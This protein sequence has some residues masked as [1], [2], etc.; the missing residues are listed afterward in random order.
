MTFYPINVN[1]NDEYSIVNIIQ[2][3]L[4]YLL[5]LPVFCIASVRCNICTRSCTT[6]WPW[7]VCTHT[8]V[9]S[10]HVVGNKNWNQVSKTE[11]GSIT[12]LATADV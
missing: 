9:L 4:S 3:E 11:C 6:P 12:A 10:E 2:T 7:Y 5:N 8:G 1:C